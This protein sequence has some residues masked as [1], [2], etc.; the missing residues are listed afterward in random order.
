MNEPSFILYFMY[1]VWPSLSA[2]TLQ[3]DDLSLEIQVAHFPTLAPS[4]E[5]PSGSWFCHSPRPIPEESGIQGKQ[6]YLSL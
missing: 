5:E 1:L 6:Q 4:N 3:S 2:I